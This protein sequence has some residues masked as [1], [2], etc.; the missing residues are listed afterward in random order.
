MANSKVGDGGTV[1]KTPKVAPA[2]DAILPREPED[3]PGKDAG[4][5][6]PEDTSGT[7]PSPEMEYAE[8][9]GHLRTDFVADSTMNGTTQKPVIDEGE[10]LEGAL[11]DAR[12]EEAKKAEEA[13]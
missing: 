7:Q 10:G 13:K 9:E 2:D 5:G 1:V 4:V 11:E 6:T 8:W 3:F 12:E